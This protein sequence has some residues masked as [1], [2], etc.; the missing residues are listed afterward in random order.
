MCA[1]S[2][3]TTKPIRGVYETVLNS[4]VWPEA[5]DEIATLFGDAK[6]TVIV[7]DILNSWQIFVKSSS[8]LGLAK[9]KMYSESF[10]DIERAGWNAVQSN[11]VGRVTTEAGFFDEGYANHPS[12]LFLEL[13]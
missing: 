10:S 9:L 3:R 5:L 1:S 6:T 2:G 12:T 7:Q 8:N 4:A 13:S 11:R